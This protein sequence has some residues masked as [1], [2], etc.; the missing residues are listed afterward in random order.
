MKMELLPDGRVQILLLLKRG[1]RQIVT[2]HG[3]RM[4]SARDV[5][6]DFD[7]CKARQLCERKVS[8]GKRWRVTARPNDKLK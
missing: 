3:N 4:H 7:F 6:C 2:R 1:V 8:R 5:Q